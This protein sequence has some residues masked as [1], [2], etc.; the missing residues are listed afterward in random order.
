[1]R[2][3]ADAGGAP[4]KMASMALRQLAAMLILSLDSP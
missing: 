2:P 4:W 1:M 3:A